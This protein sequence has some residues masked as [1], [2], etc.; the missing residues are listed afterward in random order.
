MQEFTSDVA[1]LYRR[2]APA[3]LPPGPT[4]KT[5]N[6]LKFLLCQYA[7]AL[8][9]GEASYYPGGPELSHWLKKLVERV[10]SMVLDKVAQVEHAGS[11]RNATLSH[12]S[13]RLS[14]MEGAISAALVTASEEQLKAHLAAAVKAS[15]QAHTVTLD[16][17]QASMITGSRESRP[18][19]QASKR[20]AFVEPILLAKGWSHLRWAMEAEVAYNTV[21]D[22]LT[23]KKNP[24]SSTRV[25]LAKALGVTPNLLP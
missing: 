16:A 1:D 5:P 23:G 20:K 15:I 10:I 3:K 12:H 4:P 21:A 13:V 19:D 9:K 17:R 14:D 22:Y 11:F 24:Y 8:F 2:I 7:A 25:K 6:L 18:A